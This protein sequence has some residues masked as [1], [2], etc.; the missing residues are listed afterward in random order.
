MLILTSFFED[1]TVSLG[2]MLGL[3]PIVAHCN[4]LP[5]RRYNIAPTRALRSRQPCWNHPSLSVRRQ[6]RRAVSVSRVESLYGPVYVVQPYGGARDYDVEGRHLRRWLA[7]T[8]II[9]RV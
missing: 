5:R 1:V 3:K 2:F 9:Q 8:G 7:I 4:I 6:E